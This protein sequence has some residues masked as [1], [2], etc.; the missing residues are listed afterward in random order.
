M[1]LPHPSHADALGDDFVTLLGRVKTAVEARLEALFAAKLDS[2]K[3][4]GPDVTAM[5]DAARDL[6][7]RGGKRY[8][9]GLLA[10]AYAAVAPDAPIE[11]ALQGGV[12][13][14]LLQSYLL[15]HDDWMDGDDQRRG[16]PT[17]HVLLT[18]NIADQH[19]ANASAILAGDFTHGLAIEVLATIDAPADRV[20]KAIARFA[21]VHSDVVYG[22]Q[23]DILG[24]AADV[25]VMHTLKTGS[26]TVTGPLVLGATLG[27][28][29]PDTIVA[30][31]RF[32]APIGVAFQLRDDLLG[33][34]GDPNDTGKPVGNDIRR[35]KRTAIIAEADRRL[36]DAD[37]AA[38]ARAF[39]RADA[40]DAVVIE[41][42]A[43]LERCGA[44]A[45]VTE[46]LIALCDEA[47]AYAGEIA[48]SASA[49]KILAGGAKVLRP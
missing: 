28:A 30:F 35:G 13:L 8:R 17:A 20:N 1:I 33:T 11:P 12:A 39:G 44:R 18:K 24:R 32:A 38:L 36:S 26:Y 22:Q 5:I 7:L 42:T 46:R 23:I 21:R 41:A 15:I 49:K 10:A 9:A 6:T 25:D 37:R 2:A 3:K 47:A 45:A 4:Y 31:E 27:G 34:F 14:E 16:G 48:T 40:S 19:L 43:A 29:G